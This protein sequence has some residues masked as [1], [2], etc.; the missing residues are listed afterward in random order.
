M[1]FPK[2]Y[3]KLHK[4]LKAKD[5]D[6][7]AELMAQKPEV[8]DTKDEDGTH[9]V[10]VHLPG[11]ADQGTASA[12]AKPFADDDFQAHVDQN[13]KEHEEM[14]ADIAQ[15]RTLIDELIAKMGGSNAAAGDD[16]ETLNEIA[17]ETGQTMDSVKQF[18][19]SA[20]LS[21]L[22][23][24]TVSAAEI[25]VPGVQMPTFDRAAK[26][27]ASFDAICKFRRTVLDLAYAQPETR[28][29]MDTALGGKAFDVR[30][31]SCGQ[32]RSMFH[33]VAAMRRSTNDNANRG[34]GVMGMNGLTHQATTRKPSDRNRA[35]DEKLGLNK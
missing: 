33:S 15:C 20:S 16:D 35:W 28:V 9:E 19:D 6:K 21:Q 30:K 23:Q 4:A 2:W 14:R 29:F 25:I 34:S 3:D 11:A 26:P 31:M 12:G 24:Q 17:E 7:V 13:A 5:E 8:A 32:V 22:H 10:H 18:K 27:A 1:K